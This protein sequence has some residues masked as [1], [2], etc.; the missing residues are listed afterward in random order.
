M[1][2]SEFN[3]KN[4]TFKLTIKYSFLISPMSYSILLA[5]VVQGILYDQCLFSPSFLDEL[6]IT[7]SMHVALQTSQ[8][9][10]SL[11]QDMYL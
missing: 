8:N 3:H 5:N 7:V 6:R 11:K 10:N 2:S 4:L 1:A 9:L